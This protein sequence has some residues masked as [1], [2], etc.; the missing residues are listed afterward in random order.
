MDR[1]LKAWEIREEPWDADIST[2]SKITGYIM[3]IAN[4][5]E[6]INSYLDLLHGK[7]TLQR[8]LTSIREIKIHQITVDEIRGLHRKVKK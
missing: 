2:P 4:T 7:D 8:R 6:E 1:T 3:G 5:K